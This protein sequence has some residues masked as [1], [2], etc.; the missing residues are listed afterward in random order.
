M[1]E[2]G[3]SQRLH[4]RE[5]FIEDKAIVSDSEQYGSTSTDHGVYMDDSVMHVISRSGL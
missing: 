1:G 2:S 4:T 3:T 5:Y